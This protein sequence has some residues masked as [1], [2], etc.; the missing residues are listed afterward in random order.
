MSILTQ[1]RL[2]QRLVAAVMVF[3]L[4]LA[5]SIGSFA[6]TFHDHTPHYKHDAVSA[7]QSECTSGGVLIM[8]GTAGDQHKQHAERAG[9]LDLM[10]HGGFAI[11]S[12]LAI[13]FSP[14]VARASLR[15][16]DYSG[17]GIPID[18][19]DRPPSR[20]IRR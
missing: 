2:A 18:G 7:S 14:L 10:C 9:C 20:S 13:P 17:S 8:C 3:V 15:P 6:H 4:V 16:V 1:H 11:L 19:L 12:S 5:T